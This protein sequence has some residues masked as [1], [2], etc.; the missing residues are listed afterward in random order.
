MS[1]EL[2]QRVDDLEI[3]IAHQAEVIKDLNEEITRQ[4]REID[5]L[6]RAMM[7]FQEQIE[8]LEDTRE[9]DNR[10]PPHY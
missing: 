6:T 2:E 5:K 8:E 7:R 4:N 9:P 10:P 1:S 3:H